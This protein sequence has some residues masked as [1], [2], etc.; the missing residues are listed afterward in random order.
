MEDRIHNRLHYLLDH[1]L[2]DALR[3]RN[4]FA[5]ATAILPYALLLTF[6]AVAS[7]QWG[8][9][10]APDP[11]RSFTCSAPVPRIATPTLMGSPFAFLPG[12]G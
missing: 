6:A 3:Y 8:K 4:G 2:G 9:S 11:L 1:H 5:V 10:F 7:A 12:V